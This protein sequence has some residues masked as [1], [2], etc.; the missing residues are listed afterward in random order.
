M[1]HTVKKLSSLFL[2]LSLAAGLCLTPALAAE[3]KYADVDGSWAAGSIERW[4]SNGIV[5][6]EGNGSFN[7]DAQLTRGELAQI[8]TGMFGLT[9]KA[10]NTFAD[11]RGDEWYAAAILKCVAA[12]IMKGDGASM[13]AEDSITRQ[14]TIVMFGRAVGVTPDEKPDLSNFSD[15]ASVADWA[16][17]Y[18]APLTKMGILSGSGDGTIN[19]VGLIDRAST[20]ALLDKS[21][22]EYVTAPGEYKVDNANGFVVVNAASKEGEIVISGS[23]AGVA[24]TAGTAEGKVVTKDLKADTIKVD[25]TAAVSVEGKSAVGEVV[26]NSTGSVTIARGVTVDTVTANSTGTVSNAGTVNSIVANGAAAVSNTGTIKE[27]VAN[28]P[29][30]V[31]NRGAITKADIKADGVILDGKKPKTVN[32]DAGTKNPTNSAGKEI[33]PGTDRPGNYVPSSIAVSDAQGLKDALANSQ[34]SLITLADDI[35]VSGQIVIERPVTLDGNGKRIISSDNYA[36]HVYNVD[37]GVTLRNIIA[38]GQKGAI[39]VNGSTVTLDGAVTVSGVRGGIEVGQGGGITRQS[40]LNVGSATLVHAAEA[41]DTPTV[42]MDA[43]EKGTI[44]DAGKKLSSYVQDD[45]KVYYFLNAA[46]SGAQAA[47]DQI[48]YKTVAK[49]ITAADAGKTITLLND[50][51]ANVVI[52]SEKAVVLDMNGRKLTNTSD[53][54]IINK[55]TLTITGS[56]TVD[57][58]THQKAAVYNDAGATITLVNGTFERSA[59]TGAD[60]STSGGNSYYTILNH[61]TM[62]IEASVTVNNK[63]HFSSLLEN[64]WYDGGENTG[65]QN[66]VLTINGG[67]FDGGLNTIKNDD[68]GELTINGG[69]FKNYT[70]AAFLNWNLATVNG[71][72]F[73]SGERAVLNGKLNDTMDQGKLTITGG[74]FTYDNA[75]APVQQM[76]GSNSIGDVSISGGTYSTQPTAEHLADGCI[77]TETDGVWTVTAQ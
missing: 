39:L 67:T 18:M 77:A 72:E 61:G 1:K 37:G 26:A 55:G 59:E 19:A 33:K 4:S 22:A 74:I 34:Y 45:G 68:Y 48:C 43:A 57:N 14:E 27:L 65:T 53:H 2:A 9:A 6:G 62:T 40:E 7:P 41:P 49:A 13:N 24:V 29:A 21:I 28:A 71:G 23:A 64:G 70:Q 31:D 10:E 52:P 5:T 73:V 46:N 11:L 66:S 76:G 12:G 58:V 36:I 54:T 42:W 35:S 8:F 47:I 60:A 25:G 15:A 50:V 38:D 16:A 20:M 63:G 17:P 69:M 75:G 44:T 56:G 32:V 3:T 51:T 30:K